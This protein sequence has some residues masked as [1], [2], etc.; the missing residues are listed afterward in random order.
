M[1]PDGCL[2]WHDVAESAAGDASFRSILGKIPRRLVLTRGPEWFAKRGVKLC[3]RDM[4]SMESWTRFLEIQQPSKFC[5]HESRWK[6]APRFYQILE[7]EPKQRRNEAIQYIRISTLNEW[8]YLS[9]ILAIYEALVTPLL[10]TRF[11]EEEH[12]LG[13]ISNSYRTARAAKTL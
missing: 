1:L 11:R 2:H 4:S 6:P 9:S 5:W 10:A 8:F 3:S 7:P 13:Y 12:N